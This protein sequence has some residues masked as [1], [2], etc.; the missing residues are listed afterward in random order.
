MKGRI[1]SVMSF[2][3]IGFFNKHCSAECRNWNTFPYLCT[4]N[5]QFGEMCMSSTAETLTGS[6]LK[7]KRATQE[8]KNKETK[9][10]TKS[11]TH[12]KRKD[13]IKQTIFNFNNHGRLEISTQFWYRCSH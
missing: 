12:K 5:F 3:G 6:E 2:I 9:L 4:L 10:A 13:K 11:F 7:Y 1:P 8:K